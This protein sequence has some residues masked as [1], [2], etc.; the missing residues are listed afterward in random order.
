VTGRPGTDDDDLMDLA[1]RFSYEKELKPGTVVDPN[2]KGFEV[3]DVEHDT[4]TGLDAFTF[5]NTL[6]QELTV[7]FQGTQGG[8][9]VRQDIALITSLTPSQFAAAEAYVLQVERNRGQVVSS[10]CGN[11][12]GGGLAAYVSAKNPRIRAVTVNPAPVPH[13]VADVHAPQV[14]NY[15]TPTD[16]LHRA[17]VAGKLESRIVGEQVRIAGTGFNLAFLGAN[18]VG[19]D[20]SDGVYDASMGVPFSLF[21]PG[22]VL[23]SDG[24]GAL[25]GPGAPV[26]VDADVLGWMGA[27]LSRQREDLVAVLASELDD[28]ADTLRAHEDDLDRRAARMRESFAA[29]VDEAYRPV[30]RTMAD[31]VEQIDRALRSPWVRMRPPGP[32]R[33]LWTPLRDPVLD[34]LADL[35]AGCGRVA[36]FATR[37]GAVQVWD[38]CEQGFLAESRHLTRSLLDSSEDLRADLRLVDDKWLAFAAGTQTLG[39]ALA[40]VDQD[41]AAAI[42]G[43]TCPPD[44]L[45]TSA[46]PWPAGSASPPVPD[47]RARSLRDAVEQ[48]QDAAGTLARELASDLADLLSQLEVACTAAVAAVEVVDLAITTASR[49]TRAAIGAYL[50]T[51][52]GFAL[53]AAGSTA[54]LRRFA[55]ELEYVTTC[56][57]VELERV[58]DDIRRVRG[59]LGELP[60]LVD[61]L[62]PYLR[63]TFLADAVL[64]A[65]EDGYRRC[66]NL[67]DRSRLAFAEVAH[68]LDD[69]AADAVDALA[70][71]ARDLGADLDT[72][73]DALSAMIG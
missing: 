43:R 35:A 37:L 67:V 71:N 58:E 44:A 3:V 39:T 25:R 42:A 21:H 17:V 55:D 56:V 53:T 15:I 52:A 23:R 4:T 69:H 34:A 9:D 32:L 38:L 64:E 63:D 5:R 36:D 10:V 8:T 33:V 26:A 6:T 68:H 49:A 30:R 59:T 31:V 60:D 1:S 65:A 11:S 13:A 70:E 46:P 45:P 2:G 27:S 50:L 29:D 18:H 40:Q 61:E 16:P 57:R 7:G 19:S 28:V 72:V 54:D 14:R 24:H 20:R 22:V 47:A 51:P 66:R 62:V 48:R 41:L 73:H 12:L